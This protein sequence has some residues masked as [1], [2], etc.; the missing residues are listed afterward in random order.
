[1]LND[2]QTNFLQEQNMEP[3]KCADLKILLF[4]MQCLNTEDILNGLSDTHSP[5][6]RIIPCQL[7]HVQKASKEGNLSPD[8]H[9]GR[10]QSILMSFNLKSIQ[11]LPDGDCLFHSVVCHLQFIYSPQV[12]MTIF[13]TVYNYLD[14][15]K[16]PV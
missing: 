7:D 12:S 4:A 8:F 5:A 16:N 11:V 15:H 10:L 14:I 9:Q 6:G 2:L 1:M 13:Y 3:A